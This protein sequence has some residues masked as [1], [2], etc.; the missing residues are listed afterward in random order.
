VYHGEKLTSKAV[1]S[2]AMT[3]DYQRPG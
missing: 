2:Q 3:R 1:F